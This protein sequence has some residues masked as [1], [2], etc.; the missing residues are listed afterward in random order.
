MSRVAKSSS[1]VINLT[2][3]R[4]ETTTEFLKSYYPFMGIEVIEIEENRTITSKGEFARISETELENLY[5][6]AG[7][8]NIKFYDINPL[9]LAIAGEKF[10]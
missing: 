6:N 10:N 8:N 2:W 7:L 9:W 4:D 3:K 5:K 1:L